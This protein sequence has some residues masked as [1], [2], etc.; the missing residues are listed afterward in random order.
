MQWEQALFHSLLH[1]TNGQRS[2]WEY[3]FAVAGVNLTFTLE[4]LLELRR[5]DGSVVLSTPE[6]AAGRA[7]LALLEDDK[8][9]FDK[10]VDPYPYTM[11]LLYLPVLFP[12]LVGA[13]VSGTNNTP[14][15]IKLLGRL[16]QP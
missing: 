15:K 1:K 16:A 2:D 6:G 3:P 9:A 12:L 13:T 4:E 8:E 5:R 14:S 11:F 7:F 10:V